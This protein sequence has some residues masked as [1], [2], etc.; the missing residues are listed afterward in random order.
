M[1]H[2]SEAKSQP[3]A[4]FGDGSMPLRENRPTQATFRK[5]AIRAHL[6]E[7]IPLIEEGGFIP[8]VDHT[9]PPEVSWDAFRYYMDMKSALLRGD[10]KVLE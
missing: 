9:V 4:A 2:R 10:F 1:A 3:I 8:T 6:K 7:F 5:D